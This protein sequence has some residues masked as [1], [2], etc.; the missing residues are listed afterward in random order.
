M[1][2]MPLKAQS[3]ILIVLLT[4]LMLRFL[5]GA[6]S[7]HDGKMA[8]ILMFI[9]FHTTLRLTHRFCGHLFRSVRV[10]IPWRGDLLKS[11]I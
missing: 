1:M 3:L 2:V 8:L 7:M 4:R 6:V 5:F 10:K 9:H 11:V